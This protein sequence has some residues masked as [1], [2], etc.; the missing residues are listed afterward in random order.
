MK[1]SLRKKKNQRREFPGLIVHESPTSVISEQYRTV[2]TNIK[3]S[4]VDNDLKT[5]S[6]TSAGPAS[7]KSTIASNLAVAFAQDNKKVLLVDADMRKPTVHKL[8]GVANTIGL[9][10]YLTSDRVDINEVI[11]HSPAPG[12]DYIT[13]G[14]IPPNPSEILAS[15]SFD[16]FIKEM[17]AVYDLVIIDTP[18]ILAVTDPQIVASKTEGVIFVVPMGEVKKD[19]LLKASELLENV[20]ANVLGFVMNKV[21]KSDDDYYY[22][23]SE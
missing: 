17:T 3:F 22:Y 1:F 6:V 21:E 20:N 14:V 2:R 19:Q 16:D 11:K 18:P 15:Q 9:T 7:G 8:F 10:N 12:L 5:L 13:C 23:G 4:M